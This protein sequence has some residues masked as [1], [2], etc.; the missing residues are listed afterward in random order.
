MIW[1]GS[2]FKFFFFSTKHTIGFG[3]PPLLTWSMYCEQLGT[4]DVLQ[5]SEVVDAGAKDGMESRASENKILS[6]SL[7]SA[8]FRCQV[9]LNLKLVCGCQPSPGCSGAREQVFF[10][11]SNQPCERLAKVF[12][13]LFVNACCQPDDRRFGSPFVCVCVCVSDCS[14]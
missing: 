8:I 13:I 10:P 9:P 3:H 7:S 1:P 4:F 2:R 14:V 5:K 6:H 12:P 11:L